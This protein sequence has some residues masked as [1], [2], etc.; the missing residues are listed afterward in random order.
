[1]YCQEGTRLCASQTQSITSEVRSNSCFNVTVRKFSAN[2]VVDI[3]I[4]VVIQS[5][6]CCGSRNSAKQQKEEYHEQMHLVECFHGK[7]K[8]CGTV[9]KRMGKNN[10]N[11]PCKANNQTNESV[12]SFVDEE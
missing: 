9:A 7:I 8:Q 4:H 1:M 5:C 2:L 6:T 3:K 11:P 10:S 12:V